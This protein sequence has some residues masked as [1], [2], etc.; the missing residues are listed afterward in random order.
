MK[1]RLRMAEGESDPAAR[2]K[3]VVQ[4]ARLA[5]VCQEASCPNLNHCWAQGS[6]T[7]MIM[8]ERCTRRCGFCDVATGRPLPLDASE[9]ERLAQSVADLALRHVVITSVDRDDLPDCGSAHFAAVIQAV[10]T[11]APQAIIETLIPDFKARREN[12]Q[13]IW[14]AKPDIINHN[15]ETV[16]QLYRRICPQSNYEH[17]LRV[18]AL[19]AEQGFV[20]KS[21]IILGLGEEESQV[22]AVISDLRQ[23]GVAMLT[24]GQ[25]LQP[26]REH[27]PLIEYAPPERFASLRDFALAQG[28]L[29]VESGPLVRSSYH[30]GDSFEKLKSA[31]K[32]QQD[33]SAASVV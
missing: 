4:G 23:Q 27:A 9:P 21:G 19:S 30:A 10:R 11:A 33:R 31:L 6:A 2:V 25:Y 14:D 12:L 32:K 15:V 26:G 1:V 17:S 3:A 24:I 5:T 29:H 20:A 7:F 22:R 16:P 8:G 18:L 13:R 28:F